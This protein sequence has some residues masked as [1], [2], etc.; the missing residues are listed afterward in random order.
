LSAAKE[1]KLMK[2]N[3]RLIALMITIGFMATGCSGGGCGHDDLGPVS[4]NTDSGSTAS[5]KVV[6]TDIIT[7]EDKIT[8]SW[9]SDV[10]DL[11]YVKI[12]YTDESNS[13]SGE[14]ETT[15]ETCTIGGLISETAYI[16]SVKAVDNLG[17]ISDPCIFP[18]S[19][20]SAGSGSVAFEKIET[21]DDLVDVGLGVDGH[22]ILRADIDLSGGN[23]EAIGDEANKFIGT[24]VGN[25]HVISNL[26]IDYASDYQGLFGYIG[27]G[28]KISGIRLENINVKG[29]NYSG[30]LVGW[31]LG[32]ISYCS[33]AGTVSGTEHVGGLVGYNLGG[34]TISHCFVNIEVTGTEHVGGLAGSSNALSDSYA[35]GSVKGE[36]IV[37]GLV[38][39]NYGTVTN[40]YATGNVEGDTDAGGLVG[41]NQST[42]S[43]SYATGK[44]DGKESTGG[45]VGGNRG[46]SSQITNSFA[47]GE[48]TGTENTGGLVGS[49]NNLI[50]KSYAAGKVSGDTRTGG[51]AGNNYCSINA[52][53]SSINFCGEI[54]YSYATGEVKGTTYTGGLAG[55]NYATISNSFATGK[56]SGDTETGGLAGVNSFVVTTNVTINGTISDSYATGAVIG[57]EDTGGLVGVIEESYILNCYATGKVTGTTNAGGLVGKI[58]NNTGTIDGCYYDTNTTGQSDTTGT[59]TVTDDMKTQTTF[60]GWDFAGETANGEDDIWSIDS[61]INAGYPY[62][63]GLAP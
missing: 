62:L 2:K 31:N 17:N 35:A 9:S 37:G 14:R 43:D 34:G 3:H 38:G 30:G 39:Q 56:V 54:S 50:S 21:A 41:Y 6:I 12:N 33:V 55:I 63:T 11:K 13:S 57:D 53:G 20:T 4:G 22:Y 19:T 25:G 60:A 28:G 5:G 42:I 27:F 40:C 49:N 23:W 61:E 58:I 7:G 29:G 48:V 18:V 1:K 15:D 44:V 59:P 46:F 47:T 52:S 32:G 36:E 16:I 26:T 10:T 8:F 24:F 45:L 51:L